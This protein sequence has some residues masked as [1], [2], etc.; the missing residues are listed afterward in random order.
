MRRY[1]A[2]FDGRHRRAG[3]RRLGS[4]PIKRQIVTC[5]SVSRPITAFSSK[6]GAARPA[7]LSGPGTPLGFQSRTVAGVQAGDLG[8]PRGRFTA[9]RPRTE[10]G[11]A[12]GAEFFVDDVFSH[13]WPRMRGSIKT[14]HGHGFECIS[15][16][17][18]LSAPF[19]RRSPC[20]VAKESAMSHA[21]TASKSFG[22]RNGMS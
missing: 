9:W 5:A 8:G 4:S 14:S 19:N 1:P 10:R 15:P 6:E 3:W 16:S 11:S 13:E 21:R 22:C 7:G 18:P 2:E 12:A 20:R 17:H